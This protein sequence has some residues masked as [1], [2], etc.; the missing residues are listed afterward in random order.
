MRGIPHSHLNNLTG[1][2]SRTDVSPEFHFRVSESGERQ[3]C[4]VQYVAANTR[5]NGRPD[6]W[7]R[8]D[9]GIG[10]LFVQFLGL[11]DC[12]THNARMRSLRSTRS[13]YPQLPLLNTRTTS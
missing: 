5:I 1:I 2:W 12:K 11:G 8:F 9:Q 6:E 4:L 13:R 10:A 7:W 3:M